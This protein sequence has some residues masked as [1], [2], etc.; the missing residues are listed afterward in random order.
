MQAWAYTTSAK[1]F[2]N[3][4]HLFPRFVATRS[5]SAKRRGRIPLPAKSDPFQQLERRAKISAGAGAAARPDLRLAPGLRIPFISSS[6][7]GEPDPG[8]EG[9]GARIRTDEVGSD[10]V[11]ARRDG[12][13]LAL[14]MGDKLTSH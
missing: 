6:V 11:G 5:A 3:A 7:I 10:R 9:N 8:R 4:A 2:V 12:Q 14:V 1:I 13:L